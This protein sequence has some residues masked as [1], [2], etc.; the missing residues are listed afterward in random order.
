MAIAARFL[1]HKYSFSLSD[2]AFTPPQC[3]S[4]EVAYLKAVKRA[5][6][7]PRRTSQEEGESLASTSQGAWFSAAHGGPMGGIREAKLL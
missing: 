6:T 2:A 3:I 5:V 7:W 1:H 4:R